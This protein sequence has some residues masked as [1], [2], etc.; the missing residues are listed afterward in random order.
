MTPGTAGY[1]ATGM[2][3]LAIMALVATLAGCGTVDGIGRD[4]SAAA[5]GVQSWF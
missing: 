5:R 3:R 4:I 1:E 2:R